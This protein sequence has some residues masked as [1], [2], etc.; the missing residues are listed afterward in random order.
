MKVKLHFILFT[1]HNTTELKLNSLVSK[2]WVAMLE[3]YYATLQG[4][5]WQ[6][7]PNDGPG[8][9]WT[10]PNKCQLK[11]INKKNLIIKFLYEATLPVYYVLLCQ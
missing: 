11:Q 3:N 8:Y 1:L 7:I 4:L 10:S 9:I 5:V 2:L 6:A